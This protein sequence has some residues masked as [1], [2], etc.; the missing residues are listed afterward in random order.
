MPGISDA[1]PAA[2]TGCAPRSAIGC[3]GSIDQAGRKVSLVGWSLGGIYARDLALHAPEMVRAV[4]SLGSPFTGDLTATNARRAYELL[5]GER[6]QDVDV[7]DLEALAGD[8]PVP[9]TSIYSRTDG[10]VNWRTSVLRPSASAENIEVYLASHV[11]LAGQRRGAVGGRR[12]AGAARGHLPSVRPRR[13]VRAGLCPAVARLIGIQA[14]PR[15]NY[16]VFRA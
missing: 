5:S 2:S 9:T 14:A 13:S 15:L 3:V 4:I 16:S 12:S 1:T 6:L 8:L 7:A 11:G 10:I